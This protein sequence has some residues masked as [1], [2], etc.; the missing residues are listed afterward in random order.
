MFEK[1]AKIVH[2]SAAELRDFNKS[3]N[4]TK[5]QAKYC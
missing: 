2:L 3:T 1:L 5:K 4:N